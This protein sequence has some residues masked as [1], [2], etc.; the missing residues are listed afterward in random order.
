MLE[1]LEQII[2][3]NS[4]NLGELPDFIPENMKQVTGFKFY[5]IL[6]KLQD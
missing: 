5:K 3:C 6:R 2:R 4:R 1:I